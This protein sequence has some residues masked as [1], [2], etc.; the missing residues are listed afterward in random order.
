MNR[1]LI[2]VLIFWAQS[3]CAQPLLHLT[4]EGDEVGRIP[5]AWVSADPKNITKVY[6]VQSEGGKKFLHADSKSLSVQICYEKKWDVKD[7]PILRWRWR[8]LIFPAGSNERIMSGADSV[9]GV[10][11]LFSGL[12]VVTAIK[13]I[14]SDTLPV[15]TTF[16]SPYSSRTKIIVIRSGRDL[17]GVWTTEE[18]NV[19][20]DYERFFGK[21]TKP[22]IA[23]GIVVLTDSDN[24]QSRAAG[25]YAD[26]SIH[27]SER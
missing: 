24:T 25:D 2:G 5:S 7:Y 20:S 11:A 4:F 3:L 14:W 19:L 27:P 18:R 26:I 12:P 9:L 10:Y 16:D 17:S 6:S 15:G 13:Y 8:P 21:G 1:L 23:Q 22:P